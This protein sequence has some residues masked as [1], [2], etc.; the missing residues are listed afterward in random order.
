M[1]A[2]SR[3]VWARSRQELYENGPTSQLSRMRGVDA[4]AER[5]STD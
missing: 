3:N 5:L 1:T 4:R 2:R